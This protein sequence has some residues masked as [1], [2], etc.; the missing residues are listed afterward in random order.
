MHFLTI[1]SLG[2]CSNESRD[3]AKVQFVCV[4][5]LSYFFYLCCLS[6]KHRSSLNLS[7]LI[8][9]VCVVYLIPQTFTQSTAERPMSNT[10]CSEC[11]DSISEM[12][13]CCQCLMST[14]VVVGLPNEFN[15]WWV[16]SAEARPNHQSGWSLQFVIMFNSWER[17]TDIEHQTFRL[18]HAY[19]IDRPK[20]TR[21]SAPSLSSIF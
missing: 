2:T 14:Q 20:L 19:R 17:V 7:Y 21:L 3:V 10:V 18:D 13:T 4:I 12:L 1:Y 15:N 6:N 11:Q 16:G 5:F 9:V 8:F